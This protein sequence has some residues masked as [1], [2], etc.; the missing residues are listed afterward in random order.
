M[1][2]PFE[3]PQ[4]FT[5]SGVQLTHDWTHEQ[6]MTAACSTGGG[7]TSGGGC[8]SGGSKPPSSD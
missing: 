8:S 4:L 7:C 6:V 1:Q 2:N 3:L 5:L